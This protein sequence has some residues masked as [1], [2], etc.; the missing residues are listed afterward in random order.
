MDEHRLDE[1]GRL[2]ESL[3]GFLDRMAVAR[4]SAAAIRGI[5]SSLRRWFPELESSQV[6][7]D[8]RPFGRRADL[9][10]RGQVMSPRLEVTAFDGT[11]MRGTVRFGRYFL[12]SNGAVHGGAISL[13]FDEI[14][15]H[16]GTGAGGVRARTAY[17]HVNFRSVT[18]VDRDLD[19]TA[20][21]VRHEGR[22][23]FIAG[24]L[25]DGGR[26]CADAEGLWVELKPGQP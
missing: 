26:L 19:V 24:E 25:Y 20:R 14:L 10:G 3:R 22:K 17:L 18:P 9:P 5:E 21:L 12:G 11:E 6:A 7:E 8:K 2:I 15:G 23:R 13:I 16:V 4:P 1:Y